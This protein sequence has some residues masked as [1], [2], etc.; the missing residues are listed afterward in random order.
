MEKSKLSLILFTAV[1]VMFSQNALA[2]G[3]VNTASVTGSSVASES[4]EMSGNG[5]RSVIGGFDLDKDGAYEMVV[6]DYDSSEVH[7][8]EYDAA[9][10]VF[11]LK[12]TS[13]AVEARNRTSN[14]RT[15]GVG[16]LDGDGNWEIV[17][18]NCAT[19]MEGWYIYEW[20]GVTG[21][22]NYG[23]AYSS[24]NNLEIGVSTSPG[25]DFRGDHERT[26]I[27]DVDGDGQEEL[28]IM[29]RRGSTRGTLVTSVSGDIVHNAGGT[30]FESWINEYFLDKGSYGG[31]SPYHSLPADL[32]GDGT[33]EL[34][35]HTWNYFNFYIVDVTAADTYAAADAASGTNYF[36][37]TSPDDHVSLFGGTAGDI[38][39]DGDDEA[40]FPNYYSADLWVVDYKSGD[41]VLVIDSSHVVNVV[42]D[43][44]QFYGGA[45][46]VDQN[47]K[48]NVFAG[49]SGIN[50]AELT[51]TDPRDPNDYTV[52]VIDDGTDRTTKSYTIKDS[53]GVVD[54]TVTE[55]SVFASKVIAEHRG[56]GIDFDGDGYYELLVS[57][58]GNHDSTTTTKLTWSGTAWDTT[59]TKEL[60]ER[61]WVV[62]LYEFSGAAVSVREVPLIVPEDY[63]LLGNYPN[64]FNMSTTI[65]FEIPVDKR[66]S[67]RIFNAA[68]QLIRTLV[69]GEVKREGIHRVRWDG[70]DNRGL[71]VA[72]GVY[73]TTLEWDAFS[74]SRQMMLLK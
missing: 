13:P 72:S 22:D 30:G 46:D 14:P 20:D 9:N 26:T 55:S 43:F 51:G 49:A 54:S 25:S 57:Y 32:D 12:W 44:G 45:F 17:F 61:N 15:A 52:T 29:I 8:F 1:G 10:G 74:K 36:Q 37:A 70:T 47:G 27:A 19:G 2:P 73:I 66:V 21:S 6:T 24:I 71:P 50:G 11:E 38:D 68:G 69:A 23:T 41:D 40:F 53:S 67:L 4:V 56:N 33:M 7:L 48:L 31:G 3:W 65:E 58:Q 64:P 5:A 34:V 16:D 59:V 39:G 63:K 18:P 62:A 60:N 35:N 42:P 28:V